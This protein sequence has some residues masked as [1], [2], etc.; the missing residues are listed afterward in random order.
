[1]TGVDLRTVVQAAGN[2]DERAWSEL[3]TRFRPT[4]RAVARRYRLNAPAQDDVEQRTWLALVE[5]IHDINEPAA[6]GGWLTTTARNL[7]VRELQSA[8][9]EVLVDDIESH[10]WR[11]VHHDGDDEVEAHE[12][13]SN[14]VRS[15][16]QR[17]RGRQRNLLELLCSDPA[18]SY[19][20]VSAL[21]DMPVGSIGPT[22]ARCIARLRRDPQVAELMAE[23]V[24]PVRPTRPQRFGAHDLL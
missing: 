21:L 8:D 12:L 3:F 5:R 4:V 13:R 16:V 6:I 1:M 23:T 22:R 2:G 14:A 17:V 9:R 20:D 24:R 15:A 10:Q 18:P 7:S 11:A 19:E